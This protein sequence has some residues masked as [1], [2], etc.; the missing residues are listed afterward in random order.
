MNRS[1][2][3]SKER[4][5]L[6]GPVRGEAQRSESDGGGVVARPSVRVAPDPEVSSASGRRRFSVAPS[7]ISRTCL[8]FES[9]LTAA[10]TSCSPFTSVSLERVRPHFVVDV[11]YSFEHECRSTILI[12][13][14]GTVMLPGSHTSPVVMSIMRAFATQGPQQPTWLRYEL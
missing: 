8:L 5:G 2:L 13:S 6:S 12:P 9:M 4:L 10:I 14:G 1:S 7:A 3:R 11:R